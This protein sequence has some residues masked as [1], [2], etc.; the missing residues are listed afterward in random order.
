MTTNFL[1]SFLTL[2]VGLKLCLGEFKK[3]C[4]IPWITGAVVYSLCLF[5]S[6]E[7]YSVIVEHLT[8]NTTG[9]LGWLLEKA[10]WIITAFIIFF[11]S[12]I[13]SMTVVLITTCIYK[14]NI[15]LGVLKIEKALIPIENTSIASETIR[16]IVVELKKLFFLFPLYFLSFIFGLSGIFA[17]PA[18]LLSS[19]LLTFQFV[20]EVL[21]LYQVKALDRI[22]FVVRNFFQLI[23]LGITLLLVFLIPFAGIFITPI[24]VAGT[25][26]LLSEGQLQSQ[27]K[28]KGIIAS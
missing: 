25:S 6:Y 21:D 13:I 26:W 28:E 23:G 27:I 12:T 14:G 18:F 8:P 17:I 7:K 15:I 3:Y 11:F 2:A 24:A 10:A 9:V 5:F 20:D 4:L 22:S 16:V 19:F 1:R